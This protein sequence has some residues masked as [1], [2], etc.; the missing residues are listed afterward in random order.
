[1]ARGNPTVLQSEGDSPE[2]GRVVILA[3]TSA[4]LC[5]ITGPLEVFGRASQL[6]DLESQGLAGPHA[7]Q[8]CTEKDTSPGNDFEGIIGRS[9]VVCPLCKP[10]RRPHAR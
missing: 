9:A 7:I 8:I 5:N 6:L 2:S 3:L 1:M 10:F 4:D